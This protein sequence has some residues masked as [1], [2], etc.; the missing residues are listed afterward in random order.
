MDRESLVGAFVVASIIVACAMLAV[1]M[2]RVRRAA[3]R[4]A[5]QHAAFWRTIAAWQAQSCERG[6][7]REREGT[8]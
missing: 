8:S 7:D 2:I 1:E 3:R 4:R 5:A 6:V